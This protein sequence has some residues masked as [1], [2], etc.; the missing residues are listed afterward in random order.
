MKV[1]S[2]TVVHLC[3]YLV[4]EKGDINVK[5][6][7]DKDVFPQ[8]L[9]DL[10]RTFNG[11][12]KD[13]DD[14]KITFGDDECFIRLIHGIDY[15]VF[16]VMLTPIS[17]SYSSDWGEDIIRRSRRISQVLNRLPKQKLSDYQVIILGGVD[18]KDGHKLLREYQSLDPA[19]RIACAGILSGKAILAETDLATREPFGKGFIVIPI[20]T[21]LQT[22][23]VFIP[24]LLNDLGYLSVYE[25]KLERLYWS[26]KH[27]LYAKLEEIEKEAEGVAENISERIIEDEREV[28]IEIKPGDLEL[29]LSQISARFSRLSELASKLTHDLTS[30]ESNYRNAEYIYSRWNEQNIDGDYSMITRLSHMENTKVVEAYQDMTKRIGSVRNHLKDALDIV[31][32]YFDV[33]ARKLDRH[34]NILIGLF[35]ATQF[36]EIF[37]LLAMYWYGSGKNIE[38]TLWTMTPIITVFFLILL[39]M[40]KSRQRSVVKGLIKSVRTK[41]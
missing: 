34:F 14:I 2:P 40:Y 27:P 6:A 26:Y 23:K 9:N 20:S 35:A 28:T 38:V 11:E 8:T 5:D 18:E 3:A 15:C 41:I 16:E 39:L 12:R 33:Q 21:T 29:W 19:Q 17:D 32:A 10:E 31:D 1:R 36:G 7:L 4:K 13:D 24:V 25:G 30:V 37:L 22:E